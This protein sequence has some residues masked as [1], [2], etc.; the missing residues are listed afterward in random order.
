MAPDSNA[1]FKKRKKFSQ[2]FVRFLES[3][4]IFKHFQKEDDRNS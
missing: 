3:T 1:L 4:S 2:I